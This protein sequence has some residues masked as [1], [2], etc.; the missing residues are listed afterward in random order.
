MK[1]SVAT[2]SAALFLGVCTE[3]SEAFSHRST[4]VSRT[5]SQAQSGNHISSSLYSNTKHMPVLDP[6][7]YSM[8]YSVGIVGAT[9]AVGMEI[10][11]VLENRKFPV[12]KLRIFGSG[13][14][15]G[16][17]IDTAYGKVTVELFDE[18]LAR[19]CDVV[20]LAVSGDFSLEHAKNLIAGDDGCVCIDNS[21]RK[22]K[23]TLLLWISAVSQPPDCSRLMF[24]PLLD[25]PSIF[26]VCLS[27][28][29]RYS[30]GCPRNQWRGNQKE[31]AHCQP[32]LHD[33]HRFDGSVAPPQALWF[34]KGHY[35]YLPS[36]VGCWSTRYG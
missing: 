1:W 35:D 28:R 19:E 3:T 10:R 17:E 20:F 33:C 16:K 6:P 4:F 2:V 9:G 8:S 34:E 18:K 24:I 13:R 31:Q 14:S 23:N 7:K 12:D 27:L 26:T 22:W 30:V 5:R 25:A 11:Q 21:V 32:Q 29:K 15:A 36:F